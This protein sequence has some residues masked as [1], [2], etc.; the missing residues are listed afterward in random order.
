MAT[1]TFRIV[2]NSAKL[3]CADIVAEALLKQITLD[4][5]KP[6]VFFAVVECERKSSRYGR[7][8]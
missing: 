7:R 2:S 1:K 6:N 8:K 5:A 3:L 4:T